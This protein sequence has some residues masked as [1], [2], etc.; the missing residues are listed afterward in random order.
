MSAFIDTNVLIRHLTGEPP[1]MAAAATEFL[2]D[3]PE[4][5]LADLLLAE[6]IYVL[7]SFYETAPAQVA[8]I[9]RSLL[10]LQSIVVV[11]REVLLRAVEVYEVDRLDFAEAYL[12]ACAEST[13]VGCVASFDRAVDRM[14][15]VRRVEPGSA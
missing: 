15:S 6:T 3:Q 13:G 10:A 1:A 2:R 5:F 14:A 7:E 11:D 9:V 4:L 12:V 8:E